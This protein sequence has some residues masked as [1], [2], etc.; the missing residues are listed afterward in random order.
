[1]KDSIRLSEKHGVNPSLITCFQCNKDTGVA[2]LGRLP[3]DKGAPRS[4]PDNKLCDTCEK[5]YI[6]CLEV[7]SE[8]YSKPTGRVLTLKRSALEPGSPEYQA[9][10]TAPVAL[11]TPET[12]DFLIQ[13]NS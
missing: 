2:L 8:A 5:E 7:E 10:I 9:L 12:F 6:L 13:N 3:N 4:I 11:I 1:M